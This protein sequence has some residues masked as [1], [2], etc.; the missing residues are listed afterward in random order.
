M[1]GR[2]AVPMPRQPARNETPRP[3]DNG[4]SPVWRADSF[5]GAHA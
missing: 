4:R 1:T 3:T 2:S 5:E